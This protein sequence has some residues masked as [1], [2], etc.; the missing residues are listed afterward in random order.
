MS[1]TPGRML[2]QQ[3]LLQAAPTVF[4]GHGL[5]R[6]PMV[7]AALWAKRALISPTSKGW[8]KSALR[9]ATAPI[10]LALHAYMGGDQIIG[11]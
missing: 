11:G 9:F 1:G 3:E 4:K 2:E 6:D 7:A 10:S 8:G 5:M